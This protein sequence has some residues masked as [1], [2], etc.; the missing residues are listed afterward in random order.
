[1]DQCVSSFVIKGNTLLTK[2]KIK[3]R[4]LNGFEKIFMG[5]SSEGFITHFIIVWI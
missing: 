1:M 4:L 2:V 5:A 3:V